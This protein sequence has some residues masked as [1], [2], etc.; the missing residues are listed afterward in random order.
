MVNLYHI[1][2]QMF[3]T[4]SLSGEASMVLTYS[5]ASLI[6]WATLCMLWVIYIFF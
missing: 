6:N 3:L 4:E 5:S 2:S 1:F